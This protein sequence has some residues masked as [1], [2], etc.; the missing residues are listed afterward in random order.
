MDKIFGAEDEPRTDTDQYYTFAEDGEVLVVDSNSRKH[1]SAPTTHREKKA[2]IGAQQE[3]NDRQPKAV[4]VDNKKQIPISRFP[5]AK[6]VL[7]HYHRGPSIIQMAQDFFVTPCQTK[8]TRVKV[9]AFK[10]NFRHF[11]D[12]DPSFDITFV[13]LNMNQS[14]SESEQVVF[15]FSHET[16]QIGDVV[17][18]TNVEKIKFLKKGKTNIALAEGK[19]GQI[20]GE[21]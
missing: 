6:M 21:I 19:I 2:S 9:S 16:A 20:V 4:H 14:Q 8:P 18:V 17:A 11:G 7:E 12:P 13:K 15:T 3:E 5:P 10:N 1:H